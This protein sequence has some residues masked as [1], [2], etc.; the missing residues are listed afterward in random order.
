VSN[1]IEDGSPTAASLSGPGETALDGAIERA[2]RRGHRIDITSTGRRS[3]RPRRIEIVFHNF[4]GRLYI[5][6]LPG[7]RDWY[8]NLVADPRFT[9]HLKSIVRAD[10]PATARPITDAAERR[11]VFERIARVWTRMDLE[12]MIRRSP[13][14]EVTIEPLAA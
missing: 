7:R 5:S 13:L 6:G 11:R 14:V 9:F 4:D 2:L 3:G 10:L 1:Y 12:T 8:A